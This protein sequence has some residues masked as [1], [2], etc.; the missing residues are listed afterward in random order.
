MQTKLGGLHLTQRSGMSNVLAPNNT[1]YTFGGVFD[2][3]EEEDI[4]STFL[5]EFYMLDLGA[6]CWRN[7]TLSGSK[8]EKEVKSRRRKDKNG[9]ACSKTNLIFKV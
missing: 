9:K 5:N 3:E 7:V 6:L 1:A 8:K 2:I 4:N